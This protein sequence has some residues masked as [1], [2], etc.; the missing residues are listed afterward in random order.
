MMHG[1]EDD[2]LARARQRLYA[3]L[4]EGLFCPCC[5]Q[6]AKRY[7]RRIHSGMAWAL[8]KLYRYGGTDWQY[9][10]ATRI[11][12]GIKSR[13]DVS[14]AY[15]RLIAELQVPREDGGRAGWW[16]V[17]Q[18]GEAFILQGLRIPKFAI[19][20]NGECTD[21]DYTE[22]VNIRDCL[23]NKFNLN[24]LMGGR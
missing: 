20:Y 16:H 23:G 17:T 24:D 3:N 13:D 5:D 19:V 6:Y 2:T 18:K 1:L 4:D 21:F 22:L 8:I 7:R 12:L 15:W 9:L 14:L 11:S 10:P